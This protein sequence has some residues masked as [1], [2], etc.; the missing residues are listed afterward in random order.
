MLAELQ[1]LIDRILH[2]RVDDEILAPDDDCE[3][4]L[5]SSTSR[6]A[7]VGRTRYINI[8]GQS[9]SIS[10]DSGDGYYGNCTSVIFRETT[11]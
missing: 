4:G 3:E 2:N 1:V 11:V 8:N 5:T 6:S 10:S 9:E 7:T